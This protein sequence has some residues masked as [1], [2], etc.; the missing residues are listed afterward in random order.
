MNSYIPGLTTNFHANLPTAS[1]M[2][3]SRPGYPVHINTVTK[4]IN[5]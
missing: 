2:T 4:H 3:V 1:Q 5:G